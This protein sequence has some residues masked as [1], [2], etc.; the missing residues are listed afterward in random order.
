MFVGSHQHTIDGNG[1]LILPA[2]FRPRLADGAFVTPIDNC[3]A[4]LPPGEF[5]Q[6]ARNLE[7]ETGEG[8]VGVNALRAFAS[9]ADYVVPDA[10][11]RMRILPHL[12]EAAGLDRNVVVTGAIYRV[13]VWDPD[14]WAAIQ[15]DAAEGLVEAIARGRGIGRT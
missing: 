13:E 14:R 10:Q 12:R 8:L 15:T 3:L 7:A 5:E 2:H 4:V 11:G 9:R 1:R 6:M